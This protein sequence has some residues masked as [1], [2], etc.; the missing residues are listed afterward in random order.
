MF[1]SG[2]QIKLEHPLPLPATQSNTSFLFHSP[3]PIPPKPSSIALSTSVASPHSRSASSSTQ[4]SFMR[5]PGDGSSRTR[6]PIS[7]VA[8]SSTTSL[9]ASTGSN[10]S[11]GSK[12]TTKPPLAA[13]PSWLKRTT[14]GS[15]AIANSFG[16][17]GPPKLPPRT[18]NPRDVEFL[19]PLT[20]NDNL[21]DVNSMSIP[22]EL[23]DAVSIAPPSSPSLSEGSSIVPPP[24]RR[25]A[26]ASLPTRGRSEDT[27]R[28]LGS[29]NLN[30]LAPKST[31]GALSNVNRKFAQ[32]SDEAASGSPGS[33]A[34]KGAQALKS[35]PASIG[36]AVSNGW[37]TW[38]GSKPT[39]SVSANQLSTPGSSIGS[40][41]PPFGRKASFGSASPSQ[42]ELGVGDR[43]GPMLSAA[44][45]KRH[46]KVG[47]KGEVFGVDPTLVAQRWPAAVDQGPVSRR[48]SCLPAVALR[49]VDYREWFVAA[50][51]ETGS[52]DP[53]LFN[54]S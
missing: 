50:R 17:G 52:S 44:S 32:W 25:L 20:K 34:S 51:S 40:S 8:Q 27:P 48:R 1:S 35:A 28:R 42:P 46:G 3:P 18:N 49:C 16:I 26:P 5:W 19:S 7:M 33:I 37:S 24:P 14:S 41:F 36:N 29:P 6:S 53:A 10:G 45:I 38:R 12:S 13:K 2:G 21:Q 47:V 23:E 9:P 43:D 54:F 22:T 31:A 11:N 15:K 39:S 4:V 30:N